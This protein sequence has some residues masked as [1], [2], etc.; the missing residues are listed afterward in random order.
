MG[1]HGLWGLLAPVGRRVSVETLAGKRL[2]VD[3]SIWMVQFMRAMRDDKGDM[4]RDAHILGFLRRICKLLFLRARPVFVFD[5]AT[6]ALKRRTLAARRRHRDAAQAKVRKTAE[7]LLISHLKASRLEEL[8]AQIKSDRAKHDAK[9][10]QVE[11]TRVEET[12]ITN[13]DQ[14]RND[15]GENSRGTVAP[16]N[17]EKLDELLAASLA[18]EDEADFI[19]K[20]ERNSASVTLQEGTGIDEDENDDDEE[21]IFPMTTGDLDPAVLASLP[22]SMQLDLLVQMRERVMA[23]NRQKY[24]KIKKE[25]AKFSELQIQSYLKTVAFRREIE[26]V[27]RGAAGKDVGGIQTSKIASEANREFIFSSSFTGDKQTLAQRGVDENIVNSIKSKREIGSAVFKSSP[28]SS[29]RSTNPHNGEPLTDFGPDVETY[30]DERGR[31]RVSRVRA[32]GIR[33]TRDI[34]RNL[35]FIKEHEQAKF[36][37]HTNVGKGSTS[38]EEPPDFPEHLFDNDRLQ[39]SIGPSEDFPETIGADDNISSLVG[40]SDD[41]CEGSDHGSKETIEISFVDDQIGAK[42]NDDELFLHLVSGTSSSV[43]AD[44]DRLAKNAEESDN[45]EDIWEEG[46]IE[47]ELLPK[48]VG[49]KDYHSSPPDNCF[50]DDEVEW[51]EGGFDVPDVPSSSEYNQFK[52]PRGDIEEEALI[53]EAIKRSLEDSEKQEFENGVPKDLQ[54]SVEDKPLQSYG[55]VPEPSEAPGTTYYNSETSFCKETIKELGVGSNAGEDGLM[56]DPEVLEADG[57][58]NKN[59]A[60][61][62]SNDGQTGTDRD[63]SPGS[64]PPYNVSTSTPAA[65]PSPSSKDNDISAPR[66]GEWPKEDSDEVIKHNT[67]NSHKSECNTNDPYIG[68]TSKAPQKELLM[69]ELVAN[70]AIQKENVVQEDINIIKL[71]ENYDSHIIS[72]NNL[73]EEISFLR[74]EQVDLGNERRKFESHAESVSSEMFAECQELLQMFGLPYIIAPMEAEAQCAYMEINNLVDGVVTDDSDVF[75]FGARNVYKNIFDERKY[76]E[77]YLMKDIESE[78][79]LTREQLIRMALLLGSDYTEGISGIGIVNA[80]EVVNA[81]PEEDG[82]QKFREWIESP[83]PAILGKFDM[84]TSGSSKRRKPGAN[85]SCEKGNGMQPECV[86]G[87]DD[88]QSSNEKQ[89]VKEVFMSKHRNVSKNWHIPS[90]F[91][92]DTVISAYISPQ[93]DDSTERFSWGRPDLS[94]LRKLCWERFG[95]H[96]E[97]ADELLLPVLKE[98]NKHETQLRMEAFYSFNERFAKIRSKR[99]QKAIKG[100]TGKTFSETDELNEDSPNTSSAS[101]KKEA[102][103]SKPRGKRNTSAGPR[104]MGSHEDDKIGD[105]NSFADADADELVKEHRSASKKKSAVPSGRSRGRGRKRMNVGQETSRN[106]EDSEIKGS[107]LSPDEDSHKRHTDNYKSEGTTVRRSNRKRKQVTYMEDDH[108][109]DDN[110]VPLHQVDNND[111]SQTSTDGDMA[112]RDTQ[113][114]LLRQDTSELSSDQMHED[115]H[116]AED[117]NEDPLGFELGEDQS[118]SAPKEYLFTGGGFCMEEEDEQGTAVDGSGGETVDGTSDACEDI[119][120]VSDGGKSTQAPGASSSKRRNAGPGLPTPIKRRRK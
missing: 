81:F 6:P 12:E 96:K 38:N 46:V 107:T 26:E 61:R 74:Q 22:P 47:E 24:Q 120:V 71:S 114:N 102:G 36:M 18:A 37:G 4:I 67:S 97:K 43:F 25:P 32:M 90:T 84:E 106:Q 62:E 85:E 111:P 101:K 119:G 11:S 86:E 100:I 16:I 92:S 45:S 65:R 109:A 75:L 23:E 56:H 50:A 77:T 108:E 57:Q 8:A 29:S 83:D 115:P 31:M 98:Y 60:Q 7:K 33:M 3:A 105:P 95:W 55:D 44:D 39:S 1:V 53:Q 89:H 91:P 34:Q 40:G 9:G 54:T 27:Q 63:Y 14:N 58:E 104:Q 113:F 94:L 78:L 30:R 70:T 20:G 117:I 66:T 64:L 35:D 87:P 82:L 68:E 116:I 112:G 72:E 73:Q 10:K 52:L 110:D 42:D 79:G 99:V 49:D 103:P 69:D 118:E 17:Q 51:E 13:G 21:M 41:I 48:K 93:V 80:I 28:S 59:Q 76:V 5:G 15:D 88:N 2:A 19:G